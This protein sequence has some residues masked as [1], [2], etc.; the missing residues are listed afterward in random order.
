MRFKALAA[1]LAVATLSAGCDNVSLPGSGTKPPVVVGKNQFKGTVKAEFLNPEAPA[2]Y[3]RDMKLL[4]PFGYVDPDGVS[5]DVP[6]GTITNGASVPWGF[7]NIVGG[8]YDGPYRDA[9]VVH[10]Y[11]VETKSRTWEDTHRMFYYAVL[12]R[13]VS[14]T[15][16]RTMYAGVRYG[17]PRWEVVTPPAVEPAVKSQVVAGTSTP[18]PDKPAAAPQP[19]PSTAAAPV[20]PK[21]V[22]AGPL[23]NAEKPAAP[24]RSLGRTLATDTELK[25]FDDLRQWIER[26]KPSLEEIDKAVERIRSLEGKPTTPT[27]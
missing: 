25:N 17:G 10:D 15:L 6:A 20:V 12:A 5:W 18:A 27:P 19:A 11:Y 4:E 14:D 24:V 3:Y 22:T 7:W 21:R 9:A 8:P 26:E 1:M 2:D 23:T 16:A 13:G